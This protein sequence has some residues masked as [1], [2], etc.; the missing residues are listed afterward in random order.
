MFEVI[1]PTHRLRPAVEATIRL[2]YQRAHGA[3]LASF[4]S[5]LVANTDE[6]GVIGAAALRFADDGFFSERYLDQPIEQLIARS[7]GTDADRAQLVE[8]GNLAAGRSGEIRVLVDGIIGLLYGQ[9]MRWAFFTATVAD[10]AAPGRHSVDRA[11]R[12][13]SLPDRRC[14]GMGQ[15]L[16][17][18]PQG[19]VRG[20]PHACRSV[21]PDLRPGAKARTCVR[22]SPNCR[23]TPASRRIVRRFIA[24]AAV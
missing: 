20:Q 2:A 4:P 15:L 8:V 6:T 1:A 10:S 19:G 14:H 11:G 18:G 17:A 3:R 5:W 7:A 12:G 9:G 21:A 24:Q 22:F 16:P 13:R 23:N